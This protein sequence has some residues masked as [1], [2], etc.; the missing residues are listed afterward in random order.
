MALARIGKQ[1]VAPLATPVHLTDSIYGSIP[2]Y[3]I[4]CTEGKDLNKTFL[5]TRVLCKKVYT[6]ASSHSP[7]L[8]MPEKLVE[9]LNEII[10]EIP[11]TQS[12]ALTDAG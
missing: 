2:R 11:S 3:Y 6:L 7:F 1:P 9:I 8:S 12:V 4:L 10:Q 5:T